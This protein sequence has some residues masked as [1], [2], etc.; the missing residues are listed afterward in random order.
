MILGILGG[1][2]LAYMLCENIQKKIFD[3]VDKI[4]VFSDK[5]DMSCQLL[6]NEEKIDFVYGKYNYENIFEFSKKCDI[7]TYEFENIDINILKK[8][9]KP[10]YPD[11]KYLEII[12]D[13][14]IQKEF[15]KNNKLNVGP[16]S[17]IHNL[18]DITDFIKIYN[19]P[20]IIKCRRGS[21]DGRG[22]TVIKNKEDLDTWLEKSNNF[23]HYYIE[24]YLNFENELSICGCK[25]NGSINYFEPVVNLHK[26]NILIKT[27]FYENIVKHN[28]KNKIVNLYCK[29]LNLFDTKGVICCEFFECNNDIYINE[30]ALRVHNTYHISLDC[31]NISQFE[32]HLR[33]ILDLQI[34]QLKFTKEGYMYNMISNLQNENEILNIYH[35]IK[36]KYYIKV[37]KY[38]KEP[39]GIRKIGHINFVKI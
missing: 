17:N 19:Y 7:I 35:K 6:K 10:I 36:D 37:K 33:S 28:I 3:V 18:N 23:Q 22:N 30:I 24:D 12:Q 9:E 11:I 25:N 39:L 32:L 38:N 1:G 21:F 26:N 16:Y 8:I 15:L 29:L 13:K 20:V 34:P 27:T 14:F 31:C 4:Y 5:I 2:Q